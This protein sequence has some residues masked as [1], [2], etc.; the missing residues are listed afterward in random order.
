MA[1]SEQKQAAATDTSVLERTIFVENLRT[2]VEK[3][4]KILKPV[5][6]EKFGDNAITALVRRRDGYEITFSSVEAAKDCIENG[7]KVDSRQ[8]DGVSMCNSDLL[9]NLNPVPAYIDDVSIAKRLADIGCTFVGEIK[10]AQVDG[11]DTGRRKVIVRLPNNMRS[12]PR[13]II[14]KGPNGRD[15]RIEV[16]HRN[17]RIRKNTR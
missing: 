14:V 12:L 9:V 10:R 13:A 8:Y 11:I 17:Q 6:A 7:F 2:S 3:L 4:I 1:D 16:F 15:E 5:Y